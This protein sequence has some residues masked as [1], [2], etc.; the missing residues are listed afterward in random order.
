MAGELAADDLAALHDAELGSEL[1]AIRH[2]DLGAARDE[3]SK[4]CG[5]ERRAAGEAEI[6]A[7]Y[8]GGAGA[9]VPAIFRSRDRQTVE[10]RRQ[11][12]CPRRVQ[13]HVDE[14]V[15]QNTGW[16]LER[17][18]AMP[19]LT[20]L[21]R[22][23]PARR[24]GIVTVRPIAATAVG[25]QRELRAAGIDCA[26]RGQA[27]RLSPHYYQGRDEL[28]RLAAGIERGLVAARSA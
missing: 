16:L 4:A 25:L 18:A 9:A 17:L 13:A 23:E 15:L 8:R 5:E 3:R 26:V 27:I 19:G 11:R 22:P 10:R 20:V 1:P 7:V 2:V 14:R 24:S 6:R 12:N 21:S 28:E